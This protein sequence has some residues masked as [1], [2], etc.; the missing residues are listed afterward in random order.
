MTPS[1]LSCVTASFCKVGFHRSR[2][3]QGVAGIQICSQDP[4]KRGNPSNSEE[5]GQLIAASSLLAPSGFASAL[6]PTS[7]FFQD[8]SS[9]R[10]KEGDGATSGEGVRKSFRDI[11]I[12]VQ[13]E[14][15]LKRAVFAPGLLTELV[16]TAGAASWSSN[17]PN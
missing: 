16:D 11:V 9:R 5:N 10:A 17:S 13:H 7:C 2:L 3:G 8:R 6:Q 12:F 1:F 15:L 4:F 14:I